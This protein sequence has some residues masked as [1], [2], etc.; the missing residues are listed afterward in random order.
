VTC[1]DLYIVKYGF[2]SVIH[3]MLKIRNCLKQFILEIVKWKSAILHQ[4]T[5]Q[6]VFPDLRHCE[7]SNPESNIY[8]YFHG[9]N[10]QS[11][12]LSDAWQIKYGISVEHQI[13]FKIMVLNM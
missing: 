13:S 5:C 8:V 12:R 1:S 6:E 9:L 10:K 7:R 4:V 3:I 11:L 2:V